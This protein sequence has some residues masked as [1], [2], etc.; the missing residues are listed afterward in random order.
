MTSENASKFCDAMA[1]DKALFQQVIAL[2]QAEEP[3]WHAKVLELGKERGLEFSDAEIASELKVLM[4]DELSLEQLDS[5]QGGIK[6]IRTSKNTQLLR[7]RMQ[8]F[9]AGYQEASWP[10]MPW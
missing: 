4:E 9:K 6:A 3:G 5:V 2:S 1:N 8:S 10:D 7:K